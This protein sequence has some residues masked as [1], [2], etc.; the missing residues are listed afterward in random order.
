MGMMRESTISKGIGQVPSASVSSESLAL[1]KTRGERTTPGQRML[2]PVDDL[3]APYHRVLNSLELMRSGRLRELLAYMLRAVESGTTADA[4][5]ERNIGIAVF[6]RDRDW[7]PSIDPCVRVA[8]G[9]LRTKL[10]NYYQQSGQ[11]DAAKVILLKGSYTPQIVHDVTIIPDASAIP[12]DFVHRDAAG[13]SPRYIAPRRRLLALGF[14]AIVT[15]AVSLTFMTR[16]KLRT[17]ADQTPHRFEITPFSTEAGNQFSPA[18]SPDGKKIAYVWDKN[19]TDFH[20]YIRSLDGGPVLEIPGGNGNDFYPSWSP[21]GSRLA[22]LRTDGWEGKLMVVTS[23]GGDQKVIGSV[24]ISHGRWAEDSAPV[25]GDP[26]PIWS[27]SGRELIVYDQKHFGIYAIALDGG[28][29]RQLTF[30]SDKTRD[31]YPRISPD[32]EWLAFVRYITH[33][34][35]DLYVLPLRSGGEPRQITHDQRTIRGIAWS[36]DSRSL[37]IASNRSGPFE[38]S[39]VNVQNSEISPLPS[40]TA[41]AADPVVAA[42]GKWLAFDNMH[43][44]ISIYQI[45]LDK[46]SKSIPMRPLITSLGRDRWATRSPDGM[47]IAFTS[48]RSGTWQI[49]LAERD[50]NVPKQLS[51]LDGSLTGGINWAPDSEHGV[52]DGRSSGHSAIYLIDT[53]SGDFTPLLPPSSAEYVM[54]Y[55]SAD[56]REIYFSS[57]KDGSVALYRMAVESRQVTLVADDGFRAL[58]TEDGRW[59][60]YATMSNVLWRVP[61]SGG[62]PTQLPPTLQTYSTSTWTVVGND[63]LVLKKSA[64]SDAIELVKADS[65]L[66][67]HSIGTIK[68]APQTTVLSVQSS[69]SRRDI[70][71]DVRT[72]MTSGIVLRKD[73]AEK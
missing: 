68:L 17:A 34:V 59:I 54:P 67:A 4:L 10:S 56:G 15:L 61:T 24:G 11:S 40:D 19:Q 39:T 32:G 47:K 29:R 53:A 7:D 33:G 38:L 5:T 70:L 9:R 65:S 45:L 25:F 31:F 14:L 3:P 36:Q 26:G 42:D 22:F 23:G 49:W 69:K 57:N 8:V 20:I 64:S 62:V 46:V 12:A 18:I 41:S 71:M 52:F 28:Q 30:D 63:L 51:H 44:V 43:E 27:M 13:L 6:G 72:Q 60:Y 58:P 16:W 35:G 37:T 48:D 2:P 50:G 55:W 73:L 1:P 21:D 66:Q